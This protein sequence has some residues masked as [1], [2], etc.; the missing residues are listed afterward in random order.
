MQR[1]TVITWTRAAEIPPDEALKTGMK[2]M[3]LPETEKKQ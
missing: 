2:K 3:A 1:L